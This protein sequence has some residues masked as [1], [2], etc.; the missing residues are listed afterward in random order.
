VI[1]LVGKVRADAIFP[2]FTKY[3][4]VFIS[5][6]TAGLLTNTAPSTTGQF[7]R[8]IGQAISADEI[9]FNPNNAWIEVA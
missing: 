7:V 8:C 5:E 9:W 6:A 3:A 4:P 2:T 1:L